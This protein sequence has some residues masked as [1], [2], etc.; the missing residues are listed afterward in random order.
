MCIRL[1]LL[2]RVQ[3]DIEIAYVEI[4]PKTGILVDL[5]NEFQNKR[6]QPK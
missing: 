4:L 3:N 6:V 5:L 1:Y 2:K